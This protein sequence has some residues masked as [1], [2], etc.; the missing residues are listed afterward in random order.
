[1]RECVTRDC[2]CIGTHTFIFWDDCFLA[3]RR[4]PSFGGKATLLHDGFILT[5]TNYVLFVDRLLDAGIAPKSGGRVHFVLEGVMIVDV[6]LN[7]HYYWN[8]RCHC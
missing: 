2:A 1:M 5:K 7:H 6:E 3:T 4:S 8:A